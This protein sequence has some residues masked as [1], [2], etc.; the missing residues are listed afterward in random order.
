MLLKHTSGHR[1]QKGSA[2]LFVNALK[3]FLNSYHVFSVGVITFVHLLA[4]KLV[5]KIHLHY[6]NYNFL[7]R[8]TTNEKLT[9]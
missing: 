1:F 7:L 5:R 6:A 2:V 4:V 9:Y 8:S 3:K